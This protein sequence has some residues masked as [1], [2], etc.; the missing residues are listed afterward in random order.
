MCA[1][2]LFS[3]LRP[4]LGQ[5]TADISLAPLRRFAG[6]SATFLLANYGG[7]FSGGYVTLLTTA[8]VG[9]ERSYLLSAAAGEHQ[10]ASIRTLVLGLL[11]REHP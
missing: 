1:V 7:F 10:P 9:F 4:R 8:F 6:Y 11:P 2:A 5:T 3:L